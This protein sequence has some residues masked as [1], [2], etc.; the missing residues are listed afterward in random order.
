MS[1]YF[2]V[3][4]IF[5]FKSFSETPLSPS[6]LLVSTLLNKSTFGPISGVLKLNYQNWS[7]L[8]PNFPPYK[9]AILEGW[10]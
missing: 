4:C 6:L 9:E 2:C 7:D 3:L 8:T 1:K 5:V 10:S